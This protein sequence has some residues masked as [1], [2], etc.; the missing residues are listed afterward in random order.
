VSGQGEDRPATKLKSL[1][2]GF[3]RW[4]ERTP[5]RV[6]VSFDDASYTYGELHLRADAVAV[7][8]D[9]QAL[10]AE[11]L[12][13]VLLERSL[14]L[15]AGIIGVLRA[16]AA[17]LPL[18]PSQPDQRNHRILADAQPHLILTTSDLV[19]R[20]PPEM[21]RVC[22]DLLTSPQS[23]LP[24]RPAGRDSRAYVMYTSG[25][26]GNPKGVVVTHANVLDVLA[27]CRRE[28]GLDDREV[29]TLFHRIA[30]DFSVWEMWAALLYG[31]QL[32][33]VPESV[34]GSPTDLVQ[35]LIDRQVSVLSLT[36]TWFH[37]VLD[38]LLTEPSLVSA[39]GLRLVVLG[40]E[41]FS[42]AKASAWFHT[43]PTS[44]PRLVNMYGTT[45]A[46]I[47]STVR[48]I[49][50]EDCRDSRSPIGRP[51]DGVRILLRNPAG[52]LVPDG[53]IGEICIS[54]VGLTREYLGNPTLTAERFEIDQTTGERFYRSGDLA[55]ASAGQLWYV[56]R[57]DDLIKIRGFRVDPH[58]IEEC[59]LSAGGVRAAAVVKATLAG[60]DA[61]V[62]YF[63][64][65]PST[66]TPARLQ[67]ICRTLLPLHMVPALAIPVHRLPVTANGKIDRPTLASR[68]V[69]Q[70][71]RVPVPSGQASGTLTKV[72]Q[73][74]AATQPGGQPE[75][76][77]D[78][79]ESGGNSLSA[80]RLAGE[81]SRLCG[82]KVPVS[83]VLR[84][85][86]P[87]QI[88]QRLALLTGVPAPLPRTE[89][90]SG[91][92]QVGVLTPKQEHYFWRQRREPGYAAENLP[93]GMLIEGRPHVEA[94][95]AALR[96]VAS[97]H[98]ALR[99]TFG[100]DGSGPVQVVSKTAR[101]QLDGGS[102]TWDGLEVTLTDFISRPFDLACAPPWRAGL[103]ALADGHT[104][105]V[106][107]FHH[108]IIDGASISI[109]VRELADTYSQIVAGRTPWLPEVT[110]HLRDFAAWQRSALQGE[111]AGQLDHWVNY[112]AGGQ[113]DAPSWLGELP[114]HLAPGPAG[115]VRHRLSPAAMN[116]IGETQ[117][118]TQASM[119]AILLSGWAVVA[120]ALG[121]PATQLCRFGVANR[122]DPRY[123]RT[124]G[125]LNNACFVRLVARSDDTFTQVVARTWASLITA[126]D[127]QEAPVEE[128]QRR[129][130][131]MGVHACTPEG[132]FG[133]TLEEDPREDLDFAGLAARPLGRPSTIIAK[134]PLGFYISQTLTGTV[135]VNAVHQVGVLSRT[136][137][138]TILRSLE[139]VVV[140]GSHR[141]QPRVRELISDLMSVLG[142]P[143]TPRTQI[144]ESP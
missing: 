83:L 60:E 55:S 105:L 44:A 91:R 16:G 90:L 34:T 71:D 123:E 29:V 88:G 97:R 58:E 79:F 120:R 31:G 86:T 39:L 127:N 65:H 61:L 9:E 114:D 42:P 94:L 144:T 141:S 126:Y 92:W 41:R 43:F 6:A 134:K 138:E 1:D 140:D 5:E 89:D 73:A 78:L 110:V 107:V 121:A 67:E 51:L 15:P 84:A 119:F 143:L 2:A 53:E 69:R 25:T 54:G 76:D 26:T 40:G 100:E 36:P 52:E 93:Y 74:W 122:V 139:Q 104:A 137:V 64:A 22:L 129:L 99:T 28:T 124:V 68:A 30:F 23:A 102:A 77:Q 117:V 101:P 7:A 27:A 49:T 116:A 46:T 38:E 118:G 13:A 132:V 112:H 14:D 108:I 80:V 32:V 12:V 75:P 62:A 19:G 33:V 11:P 24:R 95:A 17:Y 48:E 37:Q 57:N 136:W 125:V 142:P 59:L 98:E 72:S 66:L 47:H 21:P 128:V 8:I 135:T 56:G 4:A 113:Q 103:W 131:A 45:E 63:T 106:L 115:S 50:P 109:V 81:L 111:L 133:F 10:P 87:R 82:V 3:I 35:L 96:Y 18:D 85:R 130:A 70:E 20:I